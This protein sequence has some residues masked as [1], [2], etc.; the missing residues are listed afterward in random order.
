M[1]TED[2][3]QAATN[4]EAAYLAAADASQ[5]E[6]IILLWKRPT[7][8]DADI[9]DA[10]GIPPS[11][12]GALKAEGDTPPLFTIGR[13]LFVRTEDLRKWLDEKAKDGRPGSKNL[14]KREAA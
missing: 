10:I 5:A 11:L 1:S 4:R 6:R 14:R 7:I 3:E 12:W 13:R 2:I 8:P 9:P